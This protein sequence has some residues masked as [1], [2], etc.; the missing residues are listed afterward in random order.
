MGDVSRTENSVGRQV[1]STTAK[2]MVYFKGQKDEEDGALVT[3]LCKDYETVFQLLKG[4][5]AT[6]TL[7][8][9]YNLHAV[10]GVLNDGRLVFRSSMSGPHHYFGWIDPRHAHVIRSNCMGLVYY[11][12]GEASALDEEHL[13]RRSIEESEVLRVRNYCWMKGDGIAR[14]VRKEYAVSDEI[15]AH[16]LDVDS[17]QADS[18]F[19]NPG[20]LVVDIDE[21][22][23]EELVL[24]LLSRP[25]DVDLSVFRA[26]IVPNDAP[27]AF[28]Q[29]LV[30]AHKHAQHKLRVVTYNYADE[31]LKSYLYPGS[32]VFI[33][34]HEFIQ[35][36]TPMN[37][38]CGGFAML[39]REVVAVD[40]GSTE[41]ELFAVPIPFGCTL[42]VDSGCIHGDSTL[43][44]L[45]MMA[46]TG[47]H[48][49]MRTA[50][51]VFLKEKHSKRNVV[52][53]TQ[54][55]APVVSGLPAACFRLRSDD[56]SLEDLCTEDRALKDAILT[57]LGPIK[58]VWWKPVVR[59]GPAAL[60]WEKTLGMNLPSK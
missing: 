60:G 37:K 46:M 16:L 45:Y 2:R 19:D 30:S 33:E 27:F 25:E 1:T 36:I 11:D 31:Y 44:G 12:V 15:A 35:A 52:V 10:R 49:A 51:T 9:L 20:V 58:A 17:G 42:L 18:L 39:G 38:H 7:L 32:G 40:G 29:R 50:D 5:S 56:K 53:R 57:S 13:Q 41:L 21:M 22:D 34:K 8:N 14:D 3:V 55:P 6:R 28:N 23:E 47:N 59:S 48:H 26:Q 24:P 54:P 43:T 4:E